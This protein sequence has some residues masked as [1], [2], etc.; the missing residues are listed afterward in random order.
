MARSRQ[1]PQAHEDGYRQT[2]L[3]DLFDV[4]PRRFSGWNAHP[5]LGSAYRWALAPAIFDESIC[6]ANPLTA[7]AKPGIPTV[8]HC[9]PA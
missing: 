4:R 3:L 6:G 7:A 9:R 2:A 5:Y 8:A 1:E